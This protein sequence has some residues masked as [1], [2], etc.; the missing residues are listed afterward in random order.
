MITTF[1]K[2]LGNFRETFEKLLRNH[3]T[4]EKVSGNHSFQET[5]EKLSRNFREVR[6]SFEQ[7]E[8]FEKLSRN[9][10]VLRNFQEMGKF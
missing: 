9:G 7:W 8:S 2:V 10:K 4:F 6:A 3:L 1:K 5:F